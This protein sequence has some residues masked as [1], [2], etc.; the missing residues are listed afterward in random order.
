MQVDVRQQGRGNAALRRP[1]L[2]PGHLPVFHHPGFQPFADQADHAAVADPM[3]DKTDQPIV[4][5]RIEKP[6]NVGVQYPVHPGVADPD[7]ERVQRI[8]RTASGPEPIREPE[9]IFLVDRVQHLDHRTLDD[10]VL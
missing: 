5:D 4:V 9:E 8:M 6:G 3:L 10:L 7:G 2:R 1:H